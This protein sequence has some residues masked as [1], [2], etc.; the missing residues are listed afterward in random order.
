MNI[1]SQIEYWAHMLDEAFNKEQ[2]YSAKKQRLCESVE[3]QLFIQELSQNEINELV[4]HNKEIDISELRGYDVFEC[5]VENSN[6]LIAGWK[7]FPTGYFC[8]IKTY[9]KYRSYNADKSFYDVIYNRS[10]NADDGLLCE[11]IEAVDRIDKTH[12]KVWTPRAGYLKTIDEKLGIDVNQQCLLDRYCS[13]ND[14]WTEKEFNVNSQNDEINSLFRWYQFKG[15][16]VSPIEDLVN[17]LSKNS[18]SSLRNA[19]PPHRSYFDMWQEKTGNSKES[20]CGEA[21]KKIDKKLE[22]VIGHIQ[23]EQFIEALEN[24][25]LKYTDTDSW[26]D[27]WDEVAEEKQKYRFNELIDR[28]SWW[29]LIPDKVYK[30]MVSRSAHPEV[31]RGVSLK[32]LYGCLDKLC[33]D[34]TLLQVQSMDKSRQKIISSSKTL[35]RIIDAGKGKT[36]P[37]DKQPIYQR[38][39]DDIVECCGSY[40]DPPEGPS[41]FTANDTVMNKAF[42]NIRS[43]A[44]DETDQLKIIAVISKTIDLFHDRGPLAGCFVEG[45]DKTCKEVSNM[46]HDEIYENARSGQ[47]MCRFRVNEDCHQFY[48]IDKNDEVVAKC[49]NPIGKIG[50]STYDDINAA[51]IGS[52]EI[53]KP[54]RRLGHAKKVLRK[55]VKKLKSKYSLVYCFV[56]KDNYPALSLYKQL[57]KVSNHLNANG[58]YEVVFWK[59]PEDGQST[60]GKNIKNLFDEVVSRYTA[61]FGFDLSYMTFKVDRQPV[62]T[63]GEPCYEYD[64]DE[65]AGDWTTLG[66]IRLNPDMKSVMDRY[67]VAWHGGNDIEEFTKIIIAHELAHEVWNN[68]AD[69]QFKEAVLDEAR[70]QSFNTAYLNTVR[71][72]KL[73]EETFCEYLAHEVVKQRRGKFQS[74]II[75]KKVQ[76]DELMPL[77][78]EIE[79]YNESKRFKRESFEK[80]LRSDKVIDREDK[81]MYYGLFSLDGHCL[82]LSYLNKTPDECILVAEIQ[83]IVPGYGRILLQDIINKSCAMWLAA[84]PKAEDTLLDYYRTFG[85]EE[86]VLDH[87]K[88]A[89]GKE[90]HFFFKANGKSRE[91]ILGTIENAKT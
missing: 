50:I 8:I 49:R 89:D 10:R 87:S 79:T 42:K 34:L 44:Y 4:K 55:L 16:E 28:K 7:D 51:G 46:K 22:E 40:E 48:D 78:D 13:L 61:L 35:S 19:K 23:L 26:F 62:Y 90:E 9:M 1:K 27:V 20:I 70:E 76:R 6:F 52:F 31:S 5:K 33:Y 84:D 59:A 67:G 82:A 38:I 14:S 54:Y 86:V 43:I 69:D 36:D 81:S 57:G 2:L 65:C 39:A 85:L 66:W 91:K 72:S 12:I 25:Q 21:G 41:A 47:A 60:A 56:D 37:I 83:C 68:I 24:L 80:Y 64:E 74:K 3:N 18:S 29:D 58:Q 71:L 75:F 45:G 88:W 77:L 15:T 30:A 11:M 73:A 32:T 63:N 53:F 17:K